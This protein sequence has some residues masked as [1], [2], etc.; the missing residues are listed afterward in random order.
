MFLKCAKSSNMP[1]LAIAKTRSI[2]LILLRGSLVLIVIFIRVSHF[3]R[4]IIIFENSL[5]MF[6]LTIY[7]K[8]IFGHIIIGKNKVYLC[9]GITIALLYHECILSSNLLLHTDACDQSLQGCLVLFVPQSLFLNSLQ[10][11]GSLLTMPT[12]TRLY[13]GVAIFIQTHQS[14]QNPLNLD[15]S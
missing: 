4:F 13:L 1:T 11:C 12:T 5:F 14:T 9:G 3:S 8:I 10:D 6:Q 7:R 2:K 15:K